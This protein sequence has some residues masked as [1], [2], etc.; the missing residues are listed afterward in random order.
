MAGVKGRS[1]RKS[2]RNDFYNAQLFNIASRWLYEHWDELPSEA[3][4]RLAKE[5]S[6]KYMPIKQEIETDQNVHIDEAQKEEIAKVARESLR[7]ALTQ[8]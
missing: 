4:F 6:L 1:G 5:M 2:S 3:K 7:N 8:N